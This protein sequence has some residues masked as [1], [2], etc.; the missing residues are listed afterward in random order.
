M[1]FSFCVFSDLLHFLSKRPFLWSCD[2]C[3]SLVREDPI[4]H[5]SKEEANRV[6]EDLM[7]LAQNTAV[8]I[9]SLF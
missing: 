3:C 1:R 4:P 9:N 7:S 8:S 6:M 5:Q 2:V